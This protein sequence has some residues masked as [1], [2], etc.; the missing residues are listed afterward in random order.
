MMTAGPVTSLTGKIMD[1]FEVSRIPDIIGKVYGQE[2]PR[3]SL[4]LFR[5]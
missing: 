5:V 4:P 1:H 2:H 3:R